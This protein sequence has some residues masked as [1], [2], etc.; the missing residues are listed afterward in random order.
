MNAKIIKFSFAAFLFVGML[1][2]GQT[3]KIGYVDVP[4]VFNQLPEVKKSQNELETFTKQLQNSLKSQEEVLQKRYEQAEKE[5]P[6][7]TDAMKQATGKEL[8]AMNEKLQI[9]KQDAQGQLQKKEN[10]LMKPIEEKIQKAI[11]AVATENGYTHIFNKEMLLYHPATD[12]I[13][14]LVLKKMGVTPGAN[15]A[16]NNA[17]K[18]PATPK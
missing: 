14:S 1:V 4:S 17:P 13:S 7:M 2:Q 10:E 3:T 9:S 5:A 6:T 8:Q 18:T 15:P 11:T 12:D 16:A